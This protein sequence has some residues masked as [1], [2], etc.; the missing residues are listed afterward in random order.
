[1]S[2]TE[3]DNNAMQ[4]FEPDAKLGFLATVTPNGLPHITLI[5]AMQAK[6]PRQLMWG[7]FCEG[8]A[9][10]NVR[11][12]P[13]TAFLI[14]APDRHFWRGKASWT[15]SVNE[16]DDFA[17]FNDKPLFRYNSYFGIHTVHYMDLVETG[18]RERLPLGAI[19]Y[20]ALKGSLAA[21][22][23]AQAGPKV[24]NLFTRRIFNS[25]QATK[26]ITWVGTDGFPRIVP[27]LQ[28]RTA[29][30]N[31]VCF[32]P[33]AFGDELR[34]LSPGTPVAV[35]AMNLA[36]ENVVVR[37]QFGGFSRSRGVQLGHLTVDWVY[38]S[39]PPAARQIYPPTD[40][41]PVTVF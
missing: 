16:G 5:T 18:G 26:F 22:G 14:L 39:M 30:S 1:M 27:V 17:M 32:N 35:H 15:N 7:Q 10:D 25:L 19:V 28:A 8:S 31:Q 11:T 36:M 40:L 37:G 29:G 3:F 20:G 4:A 38:N 41:S 2:Y 24:M 6:T 34:Q 23:M 9:K 12:N 21:G 33:A 13:K